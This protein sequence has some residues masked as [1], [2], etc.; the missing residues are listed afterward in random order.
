MPSGLSIPPEPMT[1]LKFHLGKISLQE[2]DFRRRVI[3]PNA[4]HIIAIPLIH[5]LQH[6]PIDAAGANNLA[7]FAQIHSSFRGGIQ[8]TRARFDFDETQD[9]FR[10]VGNDVYLARERLAPAIASERRSVIR[11]DN[12]IAAPFEFSQRQVFAVRAQSTRRSESVRGL[13]FAKESE[14]PVPLRWEIRPQSLYCRSNLLN[15]G[16]NKM[17]T[18]LCLALTCCFAVTVWA[19]PPASYVPHRVYDA[20]EKRFTDFEAMLADLARADVVFVGEQHDDPGTH[21]LEIALLE[22]IARRRDKV[23]VALEM[24][25]RDVQAQVNDYLA[26]KI[27]EADFLK[28][29]RPWPR[30][31]TD[32]K[33]LIEFAKAKG[34]QVV[35]GNVPRRYASQVGRGGLG[36]TEKLP[37]AERGYLAKQFSCPSDDYFKRFTEAMG[38]HPGDN[39]SDNKGAPQMPKMDAAMIEKMYQAQC[40]KDETMAESIAVA[41]QAAPGALVIH[42]NGAFHS[43]YRLGTAAR[44][45]QR[46]PKA[47]IKVVSAMPVEN[48]DVVPAD[49]ERK[50]GEYL[51]F[52]LKPAKKETKN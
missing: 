15:Y 42:Y 30:Y 21:R 41:A 12:A 37:E 34:W 7:L 33:P 9:A 45:K 50:R 29:S 19:Q 2:R 40:V 38:G 1:A 52:T 23:I 28:N 10:V 36:E 6:T 5:H 22:G 11:H 18:R 31:A 49:K 27:S 13:F 8:H 26:G 32:Y 20:K 46:L 24:F 44:T 25:E 51:L 43:D 14:H 3:Q 48:L 39:K 35:A 4:H 16:E 47:N 17:L